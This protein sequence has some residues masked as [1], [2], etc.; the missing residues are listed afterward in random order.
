MKKTLLVAAAALAVAITSSQ[1]Q[2]YSANIV[3]YVNKPT[4]VGYVSMA[5]PLD[6][7]NG[8]SATNLFD[9]T[10]SRDGDTILTWTGT[11]YAQVN[12]DSGSP[13]GFSDPLTFAPK[14]A[15]V[16]PPGQ[17]FLY[18]NNNS[19]NTVTFAGTV[20][21]D[22]A[23]S[24][25]NTVGMT[26]NVLGNGTVYVLASSKLPVGGGITTVLQLAN[27]GGAIDGSTVLKPN[28]V[29]GAIHG[30]TS[31]SFDSSSPT[32]FSDPLT[33]A[34]K[35]EPQINAGEGFLFNNQSGAPINWVQSY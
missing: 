8:N 13:T 31:V 33:F 4:P 9:I 20:H 11:K 35:P 30:Y 18:Q 5:N 21:V 19:S 27:P 14:P 25:T 23:A 6:N 7:S 34:Q 24:G 12:I 1:A 2:V 26:T 15:P 17:G 32:G 10:G 3:G 29:G 22:A 16:L 28:I